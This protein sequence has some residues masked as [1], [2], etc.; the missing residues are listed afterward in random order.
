MRAADQSEGASAASFL[1]L[2]RGVAARADA[3]Y[4]RALLEIVNYNLA[5]EALPEEDSAAWQEFLRGG[6]EG[7]TSMHSERLQ[8]LVHTLDEI[9]ADPDAAAR[10]HSSEWDRVS[11]GRVLSIPRFERIGGEFRAVYRTV[12]TDVEAAYAHVLRLL[13]SR[14]LAGQLR[15]CELIS[16]RRFFLFMPDG[17]GPP[18]RYC[19]DN[20]GACATKARQAKNVERVQA[21]RAGVDVDRWREMTPEERD[22]AKRRH[23]Q[24]SAHK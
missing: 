19:I 13:A 14:P 8:A 20:K 11:A 5:E 16:C 12:F 22:A 10:R 17:A 4:A 1:A 15:R 23:K 24:R 9:Q 2:G 21:N 6:R 18:P 3:E 7:Y